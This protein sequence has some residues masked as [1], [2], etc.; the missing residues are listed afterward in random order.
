MS[1]SRKVVLIVDDNPLNRH[2]LSKT[3]AQHHTTVEAG[4]GVEALSVLER[5]SIDFVVSDVLM[6]NL[7]G[8]A[9]CR[10]VRRRPELKNVFLIL[11]TAT[12]FSPDDEELSLECGADKF[13]NKQGTPNVILKVIEEVMKERRERSAENIEPTNVSMPEMEIKKYQAGMI[14][15]SGENGL[16]I[17]QSLAGVRNLNNG[18]EKPGG[19]RMAELACENKRLETL[20]TALEQR[21][22]TRTDELAAQSAVLESCSKE[23]ESRTEELARANRDFEQFASIASHD[24]QEP[25]RAVAGCIQV[26]ERRFH[27]KID[28]SSDELIGMILSG[29]ARMKALIDGIQAYSRAGRAEG[30]EMID[31][32]ALV[33]H[34]LADLNE[35]ISEAKTEIVFAGLP[36]LRFVKTQFEQVVR[37]L[38]SNA[39]KYRSG[40]GQKVYVDAERQLDG[41]VFKITDSG[42]GF[43]QQYAKQVFG[44]FQR[45]HPGDVYI[46][47]GIGLAICKK[48]VECRGGNVWAES[49]LNEGASFF[50][51]VPD[52]ETGSA[53]SI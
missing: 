11:Y 37:I 6:P 28:R 32:G 23:L 8:Y 17:E 12:S 25:L 2:L 35:A 1:P 27:G 20:N 15:A 22:A 40:P 34:V 24:L 21:V 42:I 19:E 33:Q 10:E 41:W 44:I 31:T 52:A 29:S 18:D 46:G 45:L 5:Q 13:L 26:F 48:I 49:A 47:T 36:S 4:D 39:I 53:S 50:F 43:E 7:D 16:R 14:R 38:I 3:M 51:S 9:L 30:L